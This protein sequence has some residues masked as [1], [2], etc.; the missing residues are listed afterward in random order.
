MDNSTDFLCVF[1][2]FSVW[3]VCHVTCFLVLEF[4]C[5]LNSLFFLPIQGVG[6]LVVNSQNQLLAIQERH[7]GGF[8]RHWKLPG[9]LADAGEAVK[10]AENVVLQLADPDNGQWLWLLA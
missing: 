10:F 9:G 4:T 6:G 8:R 7:G 3:L 1:V 2:S 5:L